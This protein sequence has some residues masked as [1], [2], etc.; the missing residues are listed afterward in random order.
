MHFAYISIHWV[1]YPLLHMSKL[2]LLVYAI[3]DT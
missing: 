2:Q 1:V 3:M